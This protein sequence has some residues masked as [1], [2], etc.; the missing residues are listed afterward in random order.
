MCNQTLVMQPN[1]GHATQCGPCIGYAT[2]HGP[3]NGCAT[4][5][6]WASQRESCNG[7]V[8]RC[9]PRNV[10]AA[11]HKPCYG[12]ATQY[13]CA[14]LHGS[15]NGC[16]TQHGCATLHGLC[17]DCTTQHGCATQQRSCNPAWALRSE[18]GHAIRMQPKIGHA[19]Y[20]PEVE[21]C[22]KQSCFPL[23]TSR[24][25]SSVRC[26]AGCNLH[27]CK[28]DCAAQSGLQCLQCALLG[29]L[30]T[31]LF[32]IYFVLRFAPAVTPSCRPAW[33]SPQLRRPPLMWQCWSCRTACPASSPLTLPP[34]SNPVSTSFGLGWM[35][36]NGIPRGSGDGTVASYGDNGVLCR[37][38]VGM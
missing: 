1:S 23:A 14:T 32:A 2:Q 15:C 5:H 6:G 29:S 28:P 34:L 26:S 11:Q 17:N 8:T 9:R 35:G 33:C 16:A 3:C 20:V 24:F 7:C 27:F 22:S 38:A 37:G 18:I 19:I 12:Y 36:H 31:P 30:L 4:Q 13:G 25:G 21:H 10:Y